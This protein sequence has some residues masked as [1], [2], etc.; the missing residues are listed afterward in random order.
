MIYIRKKRTIHTFFPVLHFSKALIFDC[1]RG[2]KLALL[3]RVKL[4]ERKTPSLSAQVSFQFSGQFFPEGGVVLK[5]PYW[6]ECERL[7]C[8]SQRTLPIDHYREKTQRLETRGGD[9]QRMVADQCPM[10]YESWLQLGGP[11]IIHLSA[12]TGQPLAP[13]CCDMCPQ[14]L[15]LPPGGH[16]STAT[17]LPEPSASGAP[18]PCGSRWFFH[19]KT[20]RR[21]L[22]LAGGVRGIL[23]SVSG[24]RKLID[25]SIKG[26]DGGRVLC[27]RRR[28]L[29]TTAAPS[30]AAADA[31]AVVGRAPPYPTDALSGDGHA[32]VWRFN[33]INHILK[34]VYYWRRL[35]ARPA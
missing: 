15:A 17:P 2:S 24:G 32:K 12:A 25:I 21:L 35:A 20:L 9:G 22:D 23:K 14:R 31:A 13:I 29:L 4:K 27:R 1:C 11:D 26:D 6:G 18:L 16:Q 19:W 28:S 34:A 8:F 10:K 30:P 33:A 7:W 3:H 5:I